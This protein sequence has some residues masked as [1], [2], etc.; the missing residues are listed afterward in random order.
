M[1]A[2]VPKQFLPVGGRSLLDRTLS[3]VSASSRVDAIVIA[4]PADAAPEAGEAYRR[5][6]EGD[7][8]GQ[9]GS[10]AARLGPQRPRRRAEGCLDRPRARRGPPLRDPGLFDRCAEQAVARSG[11]PGDPRSRHREDVG[12]AAGTVVT[13]DRPNSSSR[14]PRRGS[15]RHPPGGLRPRRTGGTRRD[16][17]RVPRR[18][19]GSR[20]GRH[21]RGGGESQDHASG[22]PPDGGGAPVG[23]PDF[24][25]GLGGDAHRL[26]E[27]RPVAGGH[28]G[29]HPKGLLGH[30]DGDVLLHAVA[31][32]IYG[33]LGDR[34]IGFHFPPG[35]ERPAASPAARSSRM[36]GPRWRSW[37]SASSESTPW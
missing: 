22:G 15:A 34:D 30:S 4:L 6:P 2:V 25:V 33:A 35:Q 26:V 28:P 16:G 32:A 27:R 3:S 13:R 37:G 31:D 29:D 14:K 12:Q 7:R 21:P 8:G 1:G 23:D 24:R 17:R 11:G 19:G 10:G 36:R 5:I 20:G 18:G 9:G